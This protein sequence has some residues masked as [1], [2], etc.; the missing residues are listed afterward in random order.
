MKRILLTILMGIFLINLVSSIIICIDK[1]PPSLMNSS[2]T[3]TATNNNINLN[4]I[5]ATDIPDCSGID[6]YDIWGSTNGVNFLLIA[7]T[8]D[9]TYTDASL[10]YGNTYYYMI[11]V[12]DLAGHNEGEEALSNSL[13]LSTPSEPPPS[14]G[15]GGGSSDISYWQCGKWSECINGTQKRVCED[16][17]ESEPNR[18][19]TKECSPNFVSGQNNETISLDEN[20]EGQ[21]T[22]FLTGA[23][24]GMGNFVKSGAGALTLSVLVFT[25]LA[26]VMVLFKKKNRGKLSKEPESESTKTL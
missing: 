2:L 18:T 21:T 13:Y 12:F 1:D 19:E 5:A 10:S 20:Q 15:G 25:G 6:Y 24:T 4:W 11:H 3:L 23:V 16:I 14:G 17:F 7:N 9:T 22:N 8:L 26:V